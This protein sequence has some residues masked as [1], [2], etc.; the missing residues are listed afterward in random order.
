MIETKSKPSFFRR[1][2]REP[3]VLFAAV[4]GLLFVVAR[5]ANPRRVE[6]IEI[7][8]RQV[9]WRIQQV[10]RDRGAVLSDDERRLAEHAYI[11]EQVL[12][13]EARVRGLDD[14]QRIRSILSQKML[15]ILSGEVVQPSEAELRA[16]YEENRTRYSRPPAVNADQ[17]VVK[18][19]GQGPLTAQPSNGR[20]ADL[21]AK[22]TAGLDP[23]VTAKSGR[24]G[25]TA[26]TGVTFNDLSLAFGDDTATRIF[27]SEAGEWVGPHPTARGQLWFRVTEVLESGPPPPFESILG[28]I[29]YDWIGEREET[30]LQERLAE[31]RGRYSVTFVDEGSRP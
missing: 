19:G 25:Y 10:E 9:E 2:A 8:P 14:D 3:V 13:R 29:R 11:D 16:Y 6:V 17:I 7:D 30:L 18:P 28:H 4:A 27:E 24:F 26:L 22:L 5:I 1:A 15:L 23:E 12:V 31:L 21:S 20:S